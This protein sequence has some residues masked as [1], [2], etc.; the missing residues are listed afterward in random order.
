MKK[1]VIV[2][3]LLSLLSGCAMRNAAEEGTPFY[4]PRSEVAFGTNDG[5]IGTENRDLST[6]DNMSDM[7]A[8]YFQ[9][10]LS[11]ELSSPFPKGLRVLETR[12]ENSTFTLTLSDEILELSGI[13][14][15]VA[16]VSIARTCNALS[17]AEDLILQ[18]ADGSLHLE[19]PMDSP[20]LSEVTP[21]T[22]PT[23]GD[24]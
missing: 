3:L 9:G 16:C 1:L 19:I 13:E 8:L 22:I 21:T 17:G 23:E 6:L 20:Q 12:Q 7:L 18:S 24:E 4:Y 14:L 15:T 2:L 10:P 11:Q 5:V